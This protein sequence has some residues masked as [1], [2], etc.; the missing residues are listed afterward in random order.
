MIELTFQ[1]N[2]IGQHRITI[3]EATRNILKIDVGDTVIITIR[4][5]GD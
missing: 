4:K 1:A 2:V 3:P 5:S